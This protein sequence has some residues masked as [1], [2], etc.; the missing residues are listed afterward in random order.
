MMIFPIISY[1]AQDHKNRFIVFVKCEMNVK[2]LGYE[3]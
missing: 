3:I 1:F 2:G